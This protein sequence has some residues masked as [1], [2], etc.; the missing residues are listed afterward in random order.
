M[1][2][3]CGECQKSNKRRST[4]CWHCGSERPNAERRDTPRAATTCCSQPVRFDGRCAT[5]AGYPPS[6][7][8]PFVCQRCQAPLGWAGDC[9]TCHGSG[10]PADRAS[11]RLPGAR[12]ELSGG[13]WRLYDGTLDRPVCAPEDNAAGS[14][15]L[16]AAL[17]K[18][19]PE[20][21]LPPARL[22]RTESDRLRTARAI[23]QE[24]APIPDGAAPLAVP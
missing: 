13:H 14:R 15:A 22:V 9:R 3:T 24:M 20:P 18:A 1:A 8:C 4:E 23:L 11:W 7:E 2:W 5:G 21:E 6:A 17:R 10:T 16:R 12:Y 19:T